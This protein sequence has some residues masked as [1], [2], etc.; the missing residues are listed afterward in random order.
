MPL[1]L[2]L[3]QFNSER[4]LLVLSNPFKLLQILNL[5]LGLGVP[6]IGV[7][8][9]LRQL[10]FQR[11]YFF[12]QLL[13]R[14]LHLLELKLGLAHDPI[15]VHDFIAFAKRNQC[16][17]LV[18][19]GGRKQCEHGCLF[20]RLVVRCFVLTEVLSHQGH[21]TLLLDVVLHL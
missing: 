2:A 6:N 11:H 5:P 21:Q 8:L 20:K 12:P 9:R 16:V 18:L 14:L 10:L 7:G 17:G 15:E 4:L 1:F 19:G 13:D 3:V